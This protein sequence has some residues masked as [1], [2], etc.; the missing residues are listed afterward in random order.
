MGISQVAGGV[1][2]KAEVL[3][4]GASGSGQPVDEIS[5]GQIIK[6]NKIPERIL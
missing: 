5:R 1:D 2:L 4:G 3:A 6:E